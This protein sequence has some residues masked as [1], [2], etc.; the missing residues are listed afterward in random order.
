MGFPCGAE[1]GAAPGPWAHS[2][3]R[4]PRGSCPPT[5]VP[6]QEQRCA[7]SAAVSSVSSWVSTLPE[8]GAGLLPPT[9][10][11]TAFLTLVVHPLGL[12]FSAH[13]L[14]LRTQGSARGCSHPL[15]DPVCAGSPRPVPRPA[16]WSPPLSLCPLL[17]RVISWAQAVGQAL[18]W[19]FRRGHV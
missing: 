17:L 8:R 11:Q 7:S 14:S 5:P 3:R 16:L 15:G 13:P 18:F 19:A 1:L 2:R 10:R 12:G 9:Q 6:F 4:L